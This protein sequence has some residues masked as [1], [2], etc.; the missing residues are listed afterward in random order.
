[1]CFH[2]ILRLFFTD[3]QGLLAQKKLPGCTKDRETFQS[4]VV[5]VG[6]ETKTGKM[7]L[8]LK[9][10]PETSGNKANER[11]ESEASGVSAEKCPY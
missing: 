11:C 2:G 1:M 10:F 8:A 4:V 6:G 9:R 5:V 3:A 7:K